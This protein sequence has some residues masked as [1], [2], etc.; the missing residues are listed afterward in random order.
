MIKGEEGGFGRPSLVC[1][2]LLSLFGVIL[3]LVQD[4]PEHDEG[5]AGFVASGVGPRREREGLP[6][7]PLCPAG[8]LPHRWGDRLGAM[9]SPNNGELVFR[10]TL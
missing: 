9:V 3:G 5:G 2:A 8:H 4:R 6:G 10:T 1:L 7:T